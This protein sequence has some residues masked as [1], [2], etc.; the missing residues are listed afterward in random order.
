MVVQGIP[1][2]LVCI[3]PVMVC[4]QLIPPAD[5]FLRVFVRK[6]PPLHTALLFKG[7][8]RMDEDVQHIL[9]VPQD[10]IRAPAHYDTGAF[11]R[12]LLNHLCLRKVKLVLQRLILLIAPP[13][14]I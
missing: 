12:K 9:P 10:I 3:V 2:F 14:P 8:V 5:H 6:L 13:S 1:P 11:P 7:H 4:P